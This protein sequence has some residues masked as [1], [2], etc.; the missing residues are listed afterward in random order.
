[1]DPVPFAELMT[2]SSSPS[3]SPATA[4]LLIGCI[5]TDLPDSGLIE[6]GLIFSNFSD[7]LRSGHKRM[8]YF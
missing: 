7:Q 6:R 1:M 8:I 4:S 3:W 2:S 5:G